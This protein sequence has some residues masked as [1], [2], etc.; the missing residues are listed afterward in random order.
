M[1]RRLANFLRR[2]SDHPVWVTLFVLAMTAVAIVGYARPHARTSVTQVVSRSDKAKEK[3]PPAEVA[4]PDSTEAAEPSPPNK[5]SLTNSDVVLIVQG[6]SFFTPRASEAVRDVVASLR[7]LPVVEDLFWLDDAPPI[8]LFSL[9]QSAFPKSSA[10]PRKF[11]RAEA[12]AL[13]NPLIGGQLLS[14]DGRTMLMLIDLDWLFVQDDRQCT[15]LL[16]ETAA[17]AASTYPDVGLSFLVGG[18]VPTLLAI[19]E[20]R[21]RNQTRFQ[22]IGYSMVLVMGLILFRGLKAVLV[23]AAVP[24]LG[25]FWTLGCLRYFDLQNNPFND[26]VLPVLISLVAFTD[27]VHLMIEIRRRRAAGDSPR[28]AS[29]GAIGKVGVACF[30]TSLT[31]AIG[32]GALTL[33]N[34]EAVREFGQSCVI[35]VLLSFLAVVLVIPLVCSTRPM[36]N[37]HFGHGHGV[38][39]RS[40]ARIGLIVDWTLGRPKLM[41]CVAIVGTLLLLGISLQL[42]PDERVL[43]YLPDDSEASR[44]FQVMED[45]MGGTS[46]S[47][48]QIRWT[49]NEDPDETLQVISG[50]QAALDRHE[51]IGHPISLKSFLDV[52]P[53]DPTA[54]DRMS[55]SELLPTPLKTAFYDPAISEAVI[56]FRIR[57]VGIAAYAPVFESVQQDLRRLQRE[58][59][60]YQIWME[61]GAVRRWQNLYQVVLDLIYS[62]GSA[63][64]VIFVVLTLAF[65]SLRIG[66]ISLIPN[67]FPLAFTGTYLWLT[68]EP[69]EIASVCAFTVCLGIAVDDTIHFLTRYQEDLQDHDQLDAIRSAFVGTGVALIMTTIILVVGI[70]TVVFSGLREQR[71]FATMACLTIGSALVGDLLF[72]PPL[73]ALFRG[74]RRKPSTSN[75][76]ASNDATAEQAGSP[77]EVPAEHV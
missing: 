24:A 33:A 73:L 20:T 47:Q 13:A 36:Q 17:Q 75:D 44:A 50:A 12:Q 8:N 66:L 28:E 21:N 59:P 30:L 60:H 61:G 51:L 65:G 41:S 76:A 18:R 58:H 25:V 43:S 5:I 45:T 48:V 2:T 27:S 34:H 19:D 11:Q 1:T 54:S 42:R 55:L 74:K 15:E 10:S 14:S 35:G 26:V 40:L 72:L 46:V 71:I 63:A 56:N 31:T 32:L 37:L 64:V 38:V 62:L 22:L 6:G 4:K 16:R 49:G 23:V 69:L 29:S 70:S 7:D 9:R 57:D 67:L 3:N 77:D 39:D 68:H 53:G 52:L